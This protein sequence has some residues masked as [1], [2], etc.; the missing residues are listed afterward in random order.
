ML[1]LVTSAALFR[2]LRTGAVNGREYTDR[3]G[4]MMREEELKLFSVVGWLER[5]KHRFYKY[6]G[7]DG[8]VLCKNR[9][10]LLSSAGEQYLPM[11]TE[12]RLPLMSVT[13]SWLQAAE[14]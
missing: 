8:R 14:Q 11:H 6:A 5:L 13:K 2:A 7:R 10:A 1:L 9:S 4:Q 3:P 12:P